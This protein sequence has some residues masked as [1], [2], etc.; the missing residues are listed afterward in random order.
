MC[1]GVGGE[2]QRDAEG[3]GWEE[4]VGVGMCRVCWGGRGL[5]CHCSGIDGYGVWSRGR[6][7]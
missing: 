4:V 2:K 1:R 6:E 3:M 5:T 7:S